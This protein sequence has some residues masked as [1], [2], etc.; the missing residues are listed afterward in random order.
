[1]SVPMSVSDEKLINWFDNLKI[2]RDDAATL[3]LDTADAL[4]QFARQKP[5]TLLPDQPHQDQYAQL[6]TRDTQLIVAP[7]AIA[8]A[9]TSLDLLAAIYFP[10][11]T[12]VI[13]VFQSVA[14]DTS[15]PFQ[16]RAKLT[17][18]VYTTDAQRA[19]L[20]AHL[21]AD[22][23]PAWFPAVKQQKLLAKLV[24]PTATVLQCVTLVAAL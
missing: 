10:A 4:E 7:N 21:Q 13:G 24:D 5:S 2:L 3:S 14:G 11:D 23:H 15:L 20:V 9:N 8:A 19:D 6:I 12:F 17:S 16:F 18:Q 1:M 22:M